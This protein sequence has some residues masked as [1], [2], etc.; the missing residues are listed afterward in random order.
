LKYL[1]T[2]DIMCDKTRDKVAA[3]LEDFGDRVQLSVFEV[4]VDAA[5]YQ[6]M[7]TRLKS[8]IDPEKD[9]VRIYPICASCAGKLTVLGVAQVVGDP[10]VIVI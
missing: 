1:V 3:C 10:E 7:V 5:L 2:Y 4:D 6:R 8:L 9:S